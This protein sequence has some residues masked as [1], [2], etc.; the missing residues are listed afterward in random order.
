MR[1]INQINLLLFRN[2]YLRNGKKAKKNKVNLEWFCD[3]KNLGD[4][5]SV[6]VCEYMLKQKGLSF[7]DTVSKTKHLMA[8]GSLLGGRGFFDST[9]WGSGIMSFF[10]ITSV[11]AK[12]RIRN[13]DIRAVRGPVT[14]EA[15]KQCG[16]NCP[17]IYGDPAVLLPL[18][19]HPQKKEKTKTAAVLHFH[20]QN[21]NLIQ[22]INYIDIKTYEY[23]NFIDNLVSAEKV[24]S[25]SLHGIIMAEAY[26][27]PAVFLCE[28][29]ENEML[30]YYDWYFSTGRKNVV[31]AESMAEAIDIKPMPLPDLEEMR[32]KL[33]N[34]FPYDLWNQ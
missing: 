19:Y 33:I 20:A 30:K 16:I 8:I 25:S 14:R 23:E 4:Y 7:D 26:G 3:E 29:R 31:I 28:G 12:K 24:I 11:K 34:S 2:N 13:L 22:N 10:D 21:D 1:K 18:I 9:V 17:E 6:I 27:I 5:L 15:L 32:E